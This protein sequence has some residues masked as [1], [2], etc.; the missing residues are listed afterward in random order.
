MV[1]TDIEKES[2]LLQEPSIVPVDAVV[3]GARV[4][5]SVV[6]IATK[7]KSMES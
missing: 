1:T 2:H 7:R 5:F 3:V 6:K 4:V